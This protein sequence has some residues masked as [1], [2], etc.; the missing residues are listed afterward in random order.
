[1]NLAVEN[2]KNNI[3]FFKVD[4]RRLNDFIKKVE[5]EIKDVKAIW[6]YE[7]I[8]GEVFMGAKIIKNYKH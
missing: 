5:N 2:K 4:G 8:T 3:G 1:M 6:S 7:N